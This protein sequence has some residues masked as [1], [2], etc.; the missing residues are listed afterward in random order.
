MAIRF[1][2]HGDVRFISHHDTMRFFRRALA[3]AA[4]PVRYSEG[5]NPHPRLSLPLPRPVGMASEAEVLVIELEQPV[6]PAALIECLTRQMP[7]GVTL[8]GAWEVTSRRAI[9]PETAAYEI[10]L[11]EREAEI[12]RNG[13]DRI[14]EAETWTIRRVGREG[15]KEKV[16][17][18]KACLA[19]VR[20]EGIRLCW[21]QRQ[22]A[23]GSMRPA[24]WLESLGLDASRLTHRILR[25]HIDWSGEEAPGGT[26]GCVPPAGDHPY[27]CSD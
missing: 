7:E 8:E 11:S 9:Q 15:E 20:L 17:D 13:I 22:L 21:A 4:L 12:A 18:V 3:R 2:I 14:G 25:K 1:S 26:A 19:D 16:I 10:D 5:F 6:D 24:E 27:C 23:G